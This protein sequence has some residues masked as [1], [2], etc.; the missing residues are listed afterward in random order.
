M[1]RHRTITETNI[2]WQAVAESH[3]ETLRMVLLDLGFYRR[4]LI[5][6]GITERCMTAL[7][8]HREV[9]S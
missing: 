1:R 3:A 9:T 2:D 6:D 4:D 7:K 8:K 5:T